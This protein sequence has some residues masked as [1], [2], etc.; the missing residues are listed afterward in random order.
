MTCPTPPLAR[1]DGPAL[2]TPRLPADLIG[3]EEFA[4]S[5]YEY[6]VHDALLSVGDTESA[7]L[8]SARGIGTSTDVRTS[9]DVGTSTD[10]LALGMSCGVI[11]A[12]RLLSGEFTEFAD[13][14]RNGSW[15]GA[16]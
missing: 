15:G 16:F 12:E 13:C 14:T 8:G 4:P 7:R 5:P 2:G 6:S 10:E 3:R 11:S 9:M 1:R